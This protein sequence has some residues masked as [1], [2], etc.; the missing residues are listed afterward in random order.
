MERYMPLMP[1][2]QKPFITG[3]SSGFRI[4]LFPEGSTVCRF[5]LTR[6][7]GSSLKYIS[8]RKIGS[9]HNKRKQSRSLPFWNIC[10]EILFIL[11]VPGAFIKK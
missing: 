9:E 3:N 5:A 4:R 8:S 1:W 11:K 7:F 6:I 2:G 10:K